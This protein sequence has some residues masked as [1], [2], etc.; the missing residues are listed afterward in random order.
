MPEATAAAWSGFMAAPGNSATIVTASLPA[1]SLPA[2]V[3]P[4]LRKSLSL[5][6]PGLP[7]PTTI[8]RLA[9]SPSGA[10][11]SS[12]APLFPLNW[13]VSAARL[14]KLTA[15]PSI[16]RVAGPKSSFS[17]QKTT[18]IARGAAENGT[19]PTLTASV[20]GKSSGNQGCR[21]AGGRQAVAIVLFPVALDIRQELASAH[22]GPSAAILPSVPPWLGGNITRFINHIASAPRPSHFVD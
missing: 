9:L 10:R 13:F 14:T 6:S 15:D 3:P 19:K 4:S 17:S 11:R 21:W 5:I 7:I 8:R 18:R 1:V 20:M 12:A 16:L 2:A 22:Y